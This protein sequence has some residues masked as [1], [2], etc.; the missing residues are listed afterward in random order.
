MTQQ[1]ALNILKTGANVFLTGSPGSGK[2]YTV[3]AYIDWLRSHS[4]EPSITASTG[5]A[6]THIHGLTIHAWSGI[7][8]TENFTP[9]EIDRIA[10]KEQVAK[11]IQKTS[12]LIMDEV[13]MLSGT[14]LDA[15]DAVCRQVRG[16]DMP[17]GGIQ[18]VLVGDF[19]QLPPIAG[20]GRKV[21][22]A[23]ESEAWRS[24]NVV[25]CY[26]TEQHRQDDGQFLSLLSAIRAGN[27]ADDE[28][29]LL[30]E[31]FS[32]VEDVS[33]EIPRLYTHNAD[34]DRLNDSQL[35]VLPGNA[36]VF[37]MESTG[38]ANIIEGLKRGCLS[39]ERLSLKEGAIVM[40]T[41]NNASMGYANGTI[42][43]IVGFDTD[44]GYP[45]IET[46][47]DRIL[48][49]S[50]VE[51]VVEEEGK[52]RAKIAQV[53]LRLAW[54]ITV[55]K[56]QGQSLDAAA[57]DL[58]RAF[59]YGQ[60]YVA[61]SRVRSLEGLHLLG[62]SSQALA[63]HPLVA[64]HDFQ[65]Q[66]ASEA[67]EEAFGELD[68]SGE[69]AEIENRFILAAGG[70]LEVQD[71]EVLEGE[72]RKMVSS[73][74]NTYLETLSLIKE[75]K[76]LQEISTIRGLTFGTL[77]DHLEKLAGSKQLSSEELDRQVPESFRKHIPQI[78]DTFKAIG[79]ERLAPVFIELHERFSY[80][81][82]KLARAVLRG[83]A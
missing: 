63:V 49:I 13:S 10:G 73:K 15:V 33:L 26:L 59:E 70:T 14:V 74:Q 20:R 38:K 71:L 27:F 19:Y 50:P 56:S 31:R 57:M 8:I 46:R 52:I 69:R 39:P 25:T 29:E 30:Q 5:V 48:T 35:A 17:F 65:F 43:K 34:V 16:N 62:W 44:T 24:L 55:H 6:A 58:S 83:I 18:V 4:I 12:V 75:G 53:P 28:S 37:T 45:M 82:L 23:F 67:A 3:K 68:E 81:E 51:W 79:Y 54:A 21:P 42:G 9:Y 60:G 11:R 22:F 72:R 47:D 2:T 1:D 77:C 66:A 78:S 36:H 76:T 7:G 61:L 64:K 80:D 41:K 40:C 32:K